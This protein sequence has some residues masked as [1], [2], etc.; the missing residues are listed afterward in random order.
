ME[1][2]KKVNE[3]LENEVEETAKEVAA[4]AVVPE[5][6][7][8]KGF[9]HFPTKA[10]KQMR[11]AAKL[12]HKMERT[13]LELVVTME[14]EDKDSAEKLAQMKHEDFV[15]GAK[16]AGA[17]VAAGVGIV[18]GALFVASKVLHGHGTDEDAVDTTFEEVPTEESSNEE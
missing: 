16:K 1:E 3:E 8:K 9:L 7:K 12:Q 10:E 6:P 11:K 18:T 5:E 17:A 14:P 13:S 2:E 4:P 15:S